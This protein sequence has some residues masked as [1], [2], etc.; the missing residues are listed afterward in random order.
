MNLLVS[1][2][3]P[4]DAAGGGAAVV[5]QMLRGFTGKVYWWSVRKSENGNRETEILGGLE[6]ERHFC[7][8]P[9]G[10]LMPSR[11]LTRLKAW[12]MEHLWSPLAARDLRR[13]IEQV[14]PD[15]IWVVPH[16]WSI[17]PIH[18]AL[19]GSMPNWKCGSGR[20]FHTSIHDY[21]D[22]HNFAQRAGMSRITR[23]ARMQT[24]L[25]ALATTRDAICSPMAC[26]LAHITGLYSTLICRKGIE[27]EDINFL[28]NSFP[29]S[30]FGPPVRLAYAGSVLLHEEFAFLVD[31]L[32][33]VRIDCPLELHLFGAHDYSQRG[34]F[35]PWMFQHGNLSEEDL[36]K[37]LRSMDWGI[38]L[39]SLEDKDPSY[40]HFS[41]PAKFCTY[42][43]AGLPVITAGHPH[44]SVIKM[45]DHYEVGI[46]ITDR[47]F[48]VSDFSTALSNPQ[49]KR[50]YRPEI[51][52]CA[53]EQFD[54]EKMRRKLWSC[55][56][57][58]AHL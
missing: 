29:P 46:E 15:C 24:E 5:R 28:E 19:V 47:N 32:D 35:R 8:C 16:D 34:W 33:K 21:V 42:F 6:I 36:K 13:A 43:S 44:C 27:P 11:K 53:R 52:R 26:D 51:I 18:Q 50:K 3:F 30:R 58:E 41:F 45:A 14:K 1:T 7:G 49:A 9:P 57:G 56:N 4:P 23:M 39:M 40:N 10:K 38:S 25:Y 12:M 20:G 54:V 22:V 48:P 37:A 2:E 31:L 17:L 55:F